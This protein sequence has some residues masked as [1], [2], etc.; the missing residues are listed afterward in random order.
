MKKLSWYYKSFIFKLK[1]KI[2]LDKKNEIKNKINLLMKYLT[3][4]DL[5]R[6][7]QLEIPMEKIQ[8]K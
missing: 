7:Q 6:E 4:L 5:I 2:D 8:K 3:S 1:S